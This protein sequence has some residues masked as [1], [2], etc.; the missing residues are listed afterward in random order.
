MTRSQTLL[1][2][3]CFAIQL[4]VGNQWFPSA[5]KKDNSWRNRAI[6]VQVCLDFK[7]KYQHTY[8]QRVFYIKK[9]ASQKIHICK[10]DREEQQESVHALMELGNL[11]PNRSMWSK[12]CW[13]K[14]MCDCVRILISTSID[15]KYNGLNY[16]EFCCAIL[17]SYMQRSQKKH[18]ICS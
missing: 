14:L 3:W 11:E 8:L 5:K 7:N 16:S 13:H 4:L 2:A 1:M 18:P 12:Q 17:T 9:I 6:K 15:R 10:E